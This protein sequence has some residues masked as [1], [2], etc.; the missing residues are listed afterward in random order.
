[1]SR[2]STKNLQIWT[3]PACGEI[4]PD[5]GLHKCAAAL[6]VTAHGQSTDEV[7]AIPPESIIGTILG[8]RYEILALISQGGMGV[9]YKARHVLLGS[10]LAVKILLKPQDSDAQ[11]RFMLEAR[12][13]SQLRHPNIV[14]ISDFGVLPDGRSYLV[15]EYLNGPTLSDVLSRGRIDPLR[16]C[17]IASQIAKGLQAVHDHS[18]VHRDLKPGNIFLLEEKNS[19]DFVKIVDF[20]IAYAAADSLNREIARPLVKSSGPSPLLTS[21]EDETPAKGVPEAALENA[22]A[23]RYTLPGTLLGTPHYMAPEQAE[24]QESDARSDQYALGCILY[25]MLTGRPPF[26]GKALKEILAKHAS[27]PPVPPRSRAADAGISESLEGVVLRMLAKNRS[28]RFAAMLE[29]TQELEREI[30]TLLVERGVKTTLSTEQVEIVRRRSMTSLETIRP[31][32]PPAAPPAPVV[33]PPPRSKR[34]IGSLLLG[35]FLLGGVGGAVLWWQRSRSQSR[36][37]LSA[38]TPPETA[39]QAERLGG[40]LRQL[41]QRAL[42]ILQAGL[43]ARDAEQ[44]IGALAALAQ[45]QEA[46]VSRP[47]VE[48]M[49]SDANPEVQ[50]QAAL[51]L[52]QLGGPK[53]IESLRKLAAGSK[54]ANVQIAVAVA[55]EQLGAE[56]GQ[57]QLTRALASSTQEQRQRAAFVLAG[58][59]DRRAKAV[60]SGLAASP[61]LPMATRIS[62]WARLAQAGDDAAREQLYQ[63][64]APP[65]RLEQRMLVA[66]K[67]VEQGDERGQSFLRE[68]AQRSGPEQLT[69]ARLL[70]SP[71]EPAGAELFRRLL[72]EPQ[73]LPAARLLAT[74]GLGMSGRLSDVLLLAPF[75]EAGGD[76]R[77]QQGAALAILQIMAR[78][79]AATS[80][81]SLSWA[82]TALANDRWF[83]RQAAADVLGDVPD[84]SAVPLLAGLLRDGEA[85]VRRSA[86][87]ALGR[88]RERDAMEAL[89]GGL[90]DASSEVREESLRSI[91]AVGL[92]QLQHG[93]REVVKEIGSWFQDLLHHGNETEQ[94]VASAA[95]LRLGDDSQR[96]RLGGWLSSSDVR[97]RQLLVREAANDAEL[98]RKAIGDAAAEVRLAAAIHLAGLGDR[99][100]VPVLEQALTAGGASGLAAFGALRQLGE[101]LPVPA[102]VTRLLMSGTLAERLAVVAAVEHLPI[103]VALRLLRRAAR[104]PEPEVRR[105]TAE[106]AALLPRTPGGG[107]AGEP[108]LRVLALDTDAAV[109][110]RAGSL[111]ASLATAMPAPVAEPPASARPPTPTEPAEPA[112]P[113]RVPPR[114]EPSKRPDARSAPAEAREAA[115]ASPAAGTVREGVAAYDGKQYEKAKTL[116]E[117]A[118]AQCARERSDECA[119][120]TFDLSF[121]LGRIYEDERR[122]VDS[123]NEIDK[124]RRRSAELHLSARQKEQLRQTAQR[125]AVHVGQVFIPVESGGRCRETVLWM[126][127]GQQ[128]LSVKGQNRSFMVRAGD[129]LKLGSCK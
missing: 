69:S 98:L 53:A 57:Q 114:R 102:K 124:L 115:A 47:V 97:L 45:T 92:Y 52:G 36:P 8:D 120:L 109:R 16:A 112:E 104:D 56:E 111:L 28:E 113:T 94:V 116:L 49:I 60:L 58:R 40:D 29:V 42:A 81:Q 3:C 108:I 67:L 129:S 5:A 2:P 85:Q 41:R 93:V 105:H 118:K 9:V 25:E 121:R 90:S 99:T 51:A 43:N 50:A 30:E 37:A 44:R 72:K 22:L 54:A 6:D 123:I 11:R 70:A 66:A 27:A 48:V 106:T 100:G 73:T 4:V 91:A 86:A 24:G 125:L 76:S 38:T 75:L 10:Q 126:A 82:H 13:T 21:T 107:A 31:I 26:T 63:M 127:P 18:I 23:K 88:R 77:Q 20:G 34:V 55:L 79:P 17:R 122:W 7:A 128:S 84:R 89:R 83:I 96:Q 80:E 15:M 87:R 110:A 64:L 61:S 33:L 39:P 19:K 68:L 95:L 12:I 59:G 46:Q 65:T 74:E 35:T 62:F 32:P 1:M 101:E 119:A 117:K 71:D 78:D 103:D 14:Y